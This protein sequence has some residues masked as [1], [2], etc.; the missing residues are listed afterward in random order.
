MG[1][2]ASRMF[3]EKGIGFAGSSLLVRSASCSTCLDSSRPPYTIGTRRRATSRRYMCGRE[4]RGSVGLLGER[5][6]R[7]LD[8]ARLSGDF[9]ALDDFRMGI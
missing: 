6:T 5:R 2:R 7:Q 3:Q 9:D 1:S 8:I 4:A